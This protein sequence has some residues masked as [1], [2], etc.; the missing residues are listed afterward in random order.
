MPITITNT[1]GGA[2]SFPQTGIPVIPDTESFEI[3]YTLQNVSKI[4][5]DELIRT[6][7]SA[8]DITIAATATNPDDTYVGEQPIFAPDGTVDFSLNSTYKNIVLVSA[9]PGDGDFTVF[10]DAVNYLNK[11]NGG[12]CI[13]GD[14]S[15]A[16]GSS[17]LDLSK[18]TI[19]SAVTPGGTAA[20]VPALLF[21][22][23]SGHVLGNTLRN[24][25]VQLALNSS[26]A[27]D[28][29]FEDDAAKM[30][31]LQGLGIITINSL[32]P[33][34]KGTPAHQSV[35]N[36]TGSNAHIIALAD[37]S[38]LSLLPAAQVSTR[39][40]CNTNGSGTSSAT[41]IAVDASVLGVNF[42]DANLT[43][44]YDSSINT[45]FAV[46]APSITN[47]LSKADYVKYTNTSQSI[48][49]DVET[50][51]NNRLILVEQ[52]AAPASNEHIRWRD[53][54][55]NIIYMYDPIRSKWLSELTITVRWS[56][57]S[58]ITNDT[59][60]ATGN[61]SNADAHYG[62]ATNMT[63]IGMQISQTNTSWAC[64]GT[65][66]TGGI[67]LVKG[68]NTIGTL[69]PRAT[70]YEA[71]VPNGYLSMPYLS[72]NVDINAI[73][74]GAIGVRAQAFGAPVI[75]GL[76]LKNTIVMAIVKIKG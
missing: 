74:P 58:N 48:T 51:L 59:F 5:N 30:I 75:T 16:F 3:A 73:A 36:N 55:T 54:D 50:G 49:E 10:A 46:G 9:T 52:S 42:N 37:V 68:H 60:L 62:V 34:S 27:D 15:T 20:T 21:D 28:Y 1:S 29:I 35:I 61:V 4:Q 70:V 67:R 11:I 12:I 57:N 17:N 22:E 66:D 65:P 41:V 43:V 56:Y 76:Q 23:T 8:G 19:Q 31:Y 71:I 26:A 18:I 53:T 24:N 32:S 25:G 39:H 6:A 72:L 69:T 7:F 14:G 38:L 2:I 13:L 40:V 63:L 44:Q 33:S 47:A 64:S 45:I